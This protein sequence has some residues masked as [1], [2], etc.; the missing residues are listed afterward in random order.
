VQLRSARAA[1]G[2]SMPSTFTIQTCLPFDMCGRLRR[3][4]TRRGGA[5]AR[6][7]RP[8]G[9]GTPMYLR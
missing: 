8:L 9:G 2:L 7:D 1:S 6:F 5:G 4:R 3:K